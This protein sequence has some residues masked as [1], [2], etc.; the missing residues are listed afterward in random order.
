MSFKLSLRSVALSLLL[1]IV[2]CGHPAELSTSRK[3]QAEWFVVIANG[4]PPDVLQ[5]S[6]AQF[7]R[8]YS[9]TAQAGDYIHVVSTPTHEAI[10]SICVPS[11]GAKSRLRHK[12]IE[13]A[14][15]GLKTWLA[16]D[17]ASGQAQLELSRLPT[18]INAWRKTAFPCRIILVGDPIY[19]C[20]AQ[21]GWSM[22]E[23]VVPTDGALTSERSPFR[24]DERF[25]D[26]TQ[27]AWLVHQP[28]WGLDAAHQAAVT[29]FNR[30]FLREHGAMLVR[31]TADAGSA[32]EFEPPQFTDQLAKRQEAAGVK[33]VSGTSR[34]ADVP[35]DVVEVPIQSPVAVPSAPVVQPAPVPVEPAPPTTAPLP[36][37]VVPVVEETAETVLQRVA[38]APDQIALAINWQS[39][40]PCDLDL[41]IGSRES[42]QELNH[43]S[44]TTSF[45]QLFRDVRQNG[46]ALADSGD[47]Q[48]WEYAEIHHARLEDLTVWINAYRL[49]KPVDIKL[50]VV[51]KGVRRE[52][53]L[54]MTATQGDGGV[55]HTFRARSNAWLKVKLTN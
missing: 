31:M 48:N 17:V 55:N 46:S 32:F 10:A 11:G 15:S 14:K 37:A 42:T 40:E 52:Q 5:A 43:G 38:Q 8:L 4:L 36:A 23:G 29:R 35:L 26:D 1:L 39:A 9:Q 44:M 24:V 13:A 25:P 21:A 41:W 30:L 19:H 2:G 49:T 34:R 53:R 7:E 47:F 6:L 54:R 28:V 18:T 50:V 20:E 22:R 51:W 27:A 45:G 3:T 12:A 33:L 16:P